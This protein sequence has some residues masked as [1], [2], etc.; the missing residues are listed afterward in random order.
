MWITHGCCAQNLRFTFKNQTRASGEK[1]VSGKRRP[2]RSAYW[3]RQ[4][5]H[6]SS[7]FFTEQLWKYRRYIDCH[8]SINKYYWRPVGRFE[9]AR[10]SCCCVVFFKFSWIRRMLALVLLLPQQSFLSLWTWT[11]RERFWR[12]DGVDE[13]SSK[14]VVC[15][16]LGSASFS[17]N[18]PVINVKQSAA[19]LIFLAQGRQTLSDFPGSWTSFTPTM[20]TTSAFF[21]SRRQK[22]LLIWTFGPH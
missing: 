10:F 8:C 4:E 22:Q 1:P 5:P 14:P 13:F 15:C 9:L 20:N 16:S 18:F 11:C 2:C 19:F 3:I 7:V 6:L 21:P 17:V 12:I